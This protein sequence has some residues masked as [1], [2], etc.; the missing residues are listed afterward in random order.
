MTENVAVTAATGEAVATGATGSTA[1]GGGVQVL[2][3]SL[4]D[5]AAA[6]AASTATAPTA[7]TL[8][9]ADAKPEDW[10][11]VYDSLGRPKDAASYA[12]V[13]PDPKTPADPKFMGFVKEAAHASGLSQKQFTDFIAKVQGGIGQFATAEGGGGGAAVSAEAQQKAYEATM[14]DLAKTWPDAKAREG[15]MK[16][17]ATGINKRFGEGVWDALEKGGLTND[18]GFIKGLHKLFVDAREDGVGPVNGRQEGIGADAA[19]VQLDAMLTNADE[20]K[21]LMQATHPG[22]AAAVLKRSK[23]YEQMSGETGTITNMVK[24]MFSTPTI[25]VNAIGPE[26]R[27]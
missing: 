14:A 26:G 6:A 17:V 25:T 2:D 16:L 10:G 22:H 9:G 21:A 15:N 27:G 4:A 7:I 13:D 20:M 18:A 8:P 24:D 1:T 5:K 11:K 3:A 19:K 23:L 12:Y